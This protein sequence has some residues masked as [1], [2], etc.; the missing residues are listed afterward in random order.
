MLVD[1]FYFTETQKN[2]AD[3]SLPNVSD[4]PA[5]FFHLTD[6][7]LEEFSRS[8]KSIDMVFAG[9][10]DNVVAKRKQITDFI[11]SLTQDIKV[12]IA[13]YSTLE[14]YSPAT[15][16]EFRVDAFLDNTI[17]IRGHVTIHT[18][19]DGEF[20]R[21]VTL[22]MT[23]FSLP[24]ISVARFPCSDQNAFANLVNTV[25]QT[26]VENPVMG[27]DSTLIISLKKI[28]NKKLREFLLTTTKDNA[29]LTASVKLKAVRPEEGDNSWSQLLI[30]FESP[31]YSS[32]QEEANKT[33]ADLFGAEESYT[34]AKHDDELLQASENAKR[35]LPALRALFNKGLAPGYSIM[36]KKPFETANGNEW[37]W[38]EVTQWEGEQMTGIL[39]NDP[40]EIPDLKAGAVVIFSESEVFDYIL[41]KPDGTS[42]GNETGKILER[43]E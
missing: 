40:Y 27:N 37:M 11:H 38:I 20:C 36:V 35:R 41:N 12:V 29:L 34:I 24:E 5:S 6:A 31:D 8:Q 3:F 43:R 15:W 9:T 22:G 2:D 26:L 23:G 33:V 19:R 1:S 32:P 18:Y 25:A 14:F 13:D 7:E 10:G 28:K 16:R 21:A 17:D 39:Q 30:A 42:E 4:M